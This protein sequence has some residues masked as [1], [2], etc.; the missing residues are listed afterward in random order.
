M[1]N[2]DSAPK[3][4]TRAFAEMKLEFFKRKVAAAEI[5]IRQYAEKAA[6]LQEWDAKGTTAHEAETAIKEALEKMKGSRL[7]L[8]DVGDDSG[9]GLSGG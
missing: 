9:G 6:A 2:H 5:K 4:G 3:V 8:G 7:R 1:V